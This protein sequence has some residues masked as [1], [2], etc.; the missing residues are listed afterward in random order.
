MI[1]GLIFDLD[2]VIISTVRY[3]YSAWKKIADELNL[4]FSLADNELLKGVSRTRSFEIIL[5]LNNVS[6]TPDEIQKWCD[7]KNGYYQEF[8]S[9]ITK[10]DLLPGVYEFITDAKRQNYK[11]ALGSASRNSRQILKLSNIENLFDA[12]VDGNMVSSAKPDPEVF[13]KSAEL[14]G[15]N[16]G[17][18]LVFEDSAAGIMAARNGEMSAVG[19]GNY[20]VKELADY[21]I[22]EFNNIEL[23]TILKKI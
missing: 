14:L 20:E 5:D 10:D 19:V 13:L 15:L 11:I 7:K 6:M 1:K 23:T 16:P 4:K 9:E 12:I 21:F 22:P 18:C 3:H 2:G 8:I 17:E